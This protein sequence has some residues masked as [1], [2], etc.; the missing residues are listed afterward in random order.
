MVIIVFSL[1]YIFILTFIYGTA[2]IS[3]LR[4]LIGAQNSIDIPTAITNIIGRS[5][6]H[7]HTYYD[8]ETMLILVKR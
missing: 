6:P 2:A 3:L 1:V 8:D 4:Q 5:S 7:Q